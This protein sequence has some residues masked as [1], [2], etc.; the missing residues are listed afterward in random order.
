MSD[1]ENRWTVI[2]PLSRCIPS[3]VRNVKSFV[4]L[5]EA[6]D[7]IEA[8]NM[9]GVYKIRGI[10]PKKNKVENYIEEMVLLPE[11]REEEK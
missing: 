2:E 10:L 4:T 3:D 11:H 7:Y 1:V 5:V 6:S 8:E 9:K